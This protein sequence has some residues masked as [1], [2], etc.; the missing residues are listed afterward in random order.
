[1]NVA[2]MQPAF[3]PWQGFFEL[4]LKADRFVFLDDFQYSVQSYHQRNRLFLNK[5]QPGW[6]TVPVHKSDSF[7]APLIQTQINEEVP[8]RM[9]MWKRIKNNYSRAPFYKDIAVPLEKWFFSPHDSLGAQNIEFI[10]M[11]CE[12][13]GLKPEFRYSSN[14]QS[15]SARSQ[16]V[17]DILRWCGADVY[18]CA[19]GSFSYMREDA[20]FPVADITVKFQDFVPKPYPQ[21]GSPEV[22][23]PFLSILDALFNVGPERTLAL[24]RDGTERWLT[25]E[26]MV[27]KE[28]GQP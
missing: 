12:W 11:A 25:W 20:V 5:G 13:L 16:K 26:E 19:Q 4:I 6:Y 15:P 7:L 22:F 10:K 9:K 27:E 23:V 1:M 3:L 21:C 8:W 2:M 14:F 18:F 24:V 17:L 28:K